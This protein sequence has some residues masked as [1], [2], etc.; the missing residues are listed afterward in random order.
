MMQSVE[1]SVRRDLNSSGQDALDAVVDQSLKPP[2]ERAKIVISFQGKD[3]HKQIR[4]YKDEKFERLFKMYADN[5]KLDI[6]SLAFSFDGDKVNPTATPDDLGM[7]DDDII[8]V[9][10]KKR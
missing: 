1:E 8:A 5:V 3:G 4:V 2:P 7:E 10:V 6:Q 9:H